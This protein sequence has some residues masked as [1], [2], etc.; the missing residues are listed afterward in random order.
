MVVNT[1]GTY[2][3]TPN[4][5]YHGPDNFDVTVSDGNGGSVTVTVNVTVNPVNDIPTGTPDAPVTNEDVAV[6]GAVTGTDRMG[7][8]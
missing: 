6:S 8:T 2:T 1:D 5:G 3:Y 7:C 4:A